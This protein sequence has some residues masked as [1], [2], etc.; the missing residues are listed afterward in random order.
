MY[1]AVL[2]RIQILTD[3][4]TL[5]WFLHLLAACMGIGV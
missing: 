5:A 4:T 2:A 1:C 3:Q